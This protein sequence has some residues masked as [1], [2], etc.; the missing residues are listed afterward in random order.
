MERLV[1]AQ[2]RNAEEALED[3]AAGAS[4]VVRMEAVGAGD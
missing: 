1:R 2:Q 3:A 4:N